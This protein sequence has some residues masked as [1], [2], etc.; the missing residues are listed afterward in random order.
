MKS[1]FILV[2]SFHAYAQKIDSITTFANLD[3]KLT[4]LQKQKITNFEKSIIIANDKDNKS[5]IV[6]QLSLTNQIYKIPNTTQIRLELYKDLYDIHGF[7]FK[8]LQVQDIL[9]AIYSDL[10]NSYLNGE[11]LASHP[12]KALN[13]YISLLKH[14]DFPKFS[15]DKIT[16]ILSNKQFFPNRNLLES[17]WLKYDSN[18]NQISI[19]QAIEDYE[20]KEVIAM[21]ITEERKFTN[22]NF[23]KNLNLKLKKT[24]A[25]TLQLQESMLKDNKVTKQELTDAYMQLN[26]ILGDSERISINLNSVSVYN[27]IMLFLEVVPD[28]YDSNIKIN[29]DLK[30]NTI[31]IYARDFPS[32]LG[33]YQL[34]NHLNISVSCDKNTIH[35]INNSAS[36][37]RTKSIFIPGLMVKKEIIKVNEDNFVNIQWDNNS[38]YVGGYINDSAQGPGEYTFKDNKNQVLYKLSGYFQNGFLNGNGREESLDDNFETSGKYKDGHLDGK[39]REINVVSFENFINYN[40]LFTEGYFNGKGQIYFRRKEYLTSE[41]YQQEKRMKHNIK[42]NLVNLNDYILFEGE[43]K[44]HKAHGKGYCYMTE[45]NYTCEFYKG[46]LIG[47]DDSIILPHYIHL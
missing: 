11:H 23:C 35:L 47:V 3:S 13:I 38:S 41:D 14:S 10:S 4:N 17:I 9:N 7:K 20:K 29:D 22:T 46:Y 27:L 30:N 31:S 16:D 45:V 37:I 36:N 24:Q 21:D 34:L 42:N 39:G 1:I 26:D 8:G 43:I 15:L 33:L 12:E 25:L 19:D 44:N 18:S 5:Q 6:E 32:N 28:L 2:L 40:G